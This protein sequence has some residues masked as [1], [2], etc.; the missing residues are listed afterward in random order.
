MRG[1]LRRFGNAPPPAR[2]YGHR[3]VQTPALGEEF[4]VFH[5]G[6][7]RTHHEG[8]SGQI[9]A[10]RLVTMPGHRITH[11]QRILGKTAKVHVRAHTYQ[12]LHAR[13]RLNEGAHLT[14]ATEAQSAGHLENARRVDAITDLV[15]A[16]AAAQIAPTDGVMHEVLKI[17]ELRLRPGKDQISAQR[18]LRQSGLKMGVQPDGDRAGIGAVPRTW[19]CDV[20]R[21]DDFSPEA[22]LQK[23]AKAARGAACPIRPPH[24]ARRY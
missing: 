24:A 6:D 12:C 5:M 11:Q 21:A 18:E 20:L 8:K 3:S 22:Q 23:L 14:C 2:G 16:H 15:A 10:D 7:I 17:V 1:A 19:R 4:A 9:I 13:A